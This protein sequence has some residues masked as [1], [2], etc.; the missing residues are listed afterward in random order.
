[1]SVGGRI[2]E[3]VPHGDQTWIDTFDDRTHCAI[4]I[5]KTTLPLKVGDHLWWQG[6]WAFWTPHDRSMTYVKIER[7]G[8]SGVNRPEHGAR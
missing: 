3:I 2:T 7:V 1:M 6:R 4:Y 8:Y 5:K